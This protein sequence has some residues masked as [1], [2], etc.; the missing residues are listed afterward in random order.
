[1]LPLFATAIFWGCDWALRWFTF[2][3][4]RSP[5]EN[6]HIVRFRRKESVRTNYKKNKLQKKSL[7]NK[8]LKE[9]M[10]FKKI[11]I[12]E[13]KDFTEVWRESRTSAEDFLSMCWLA[14]FLFMVSFLTLLAW[15]YLHLL[16]RLYC[17]NLNVHIILYI[18]FLSYMG[19]ATPI[20][21]SGACMW[22]PLSMYI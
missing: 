1:M 11:W 20:L 6:I 21:Y 8:L 13:K 3:C 18:G 12:L 2:Q 17:I 5:R 19:R 14:F 9:M 7:R 16:N 4:H 10:K 22:V 15:I